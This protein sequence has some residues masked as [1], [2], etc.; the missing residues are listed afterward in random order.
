MIPL[1]DLTGQRFGKLTV[2]KRAP[3]QGKKQAVFWRCRCDCGLHKIARSDHLIRGAVPNT[4]VLTRRR[5]VSRITAGGEL[6]C[7]KRGQIASL[8]FMPIWGNA[9]LEKRL[10]VSTTTGITSRG[11]A[12]GLHTKSKTTTGERVLFPLKGAEFL[13]GNIDLAY[14][15]AKGAHQDFQRR[16]LLAWPQLAHGPGA[17]VLAFFQ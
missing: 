15:Q 2:I 13:I 5:P 10:T 12:D 17:L 4:A 14:P 16:P 3:Q 6:Q 7:A 11:T 9:R 1:R 8:S